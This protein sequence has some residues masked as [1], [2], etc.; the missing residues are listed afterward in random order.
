M[1]S[2]PPSRTP[3]K[4]STPGHRENEVLACLSGFRVDVKVLED[5][6][7]MRWDAI[8]MPPACG[9]PAL[10]PLFDLIDRVDT[11]KGRLTTISYAVATSWENISASIYFI[12]KRLA[13]AKGDWAQH[14]AMISM[15]HMLKTGI[16]FDTG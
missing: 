4:S 2:P 13:H 14:L 8:Q 6:T 11:L 5:G 16:P 7:L 12:E 9:P 3:T 15:T 1:L 10:F